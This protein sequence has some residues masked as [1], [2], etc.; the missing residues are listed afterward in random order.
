MKF[1]LFLFS[2]LPFIGISQVDFTWAD[3]VEGDF[4]FIENWDY[5]EGI[6][7]NKWGQLSCDGFCPIEIDRMKDDQGRIYDDSLT[8]FYSYVDTTH[9]HYT[10]EGTAK[11]YGFEECHYASAKVLLGKVHIQTHVNMSTHTSLHIVFDP[12]EAFEKRTFKIYLIYNSIRNVPR[13]YF[14]ALNG[15]VEISK[16]KFDEGII[17]MKFDLV[18]QSEGEDELQSWEGKI[19]TRLD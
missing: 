15:N 17:Q 13:Q 6:Y 5:E 7:V 2:V 16:K 12:N 3:S 10:H 14:I 18:F 4:S 11:S 1:I 9:H 8:A 19:L